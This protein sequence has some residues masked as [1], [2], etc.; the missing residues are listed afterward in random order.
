M[1]TKFRWWIKPPRG[2]GRRRALALAL[3]IATIRRVARTTSLL[4]DSYGRYHRRT[5]VQADVSEDLTR[6]PRQPPR[7][8]GT[9]SAFA[10]AL[11]MHALLA[12]FLFSGMHGPG[13]APAGA[14]PA[15]AGRPAAPRLAA[16][17]PHVPDQPAASF[18]TGQ[19]TRPAAGN[20]Y[21]T[22]A[23]HHKI[24]RPPRARLAPQ[25][26]AHPPPTQRLRTH[27]VE[28]S[29]GEQQANAS[30]AREHETR[31]TALQ[32][33][34]AAPLAD[35]DL[36]ETDRGAAAS[37]GYAGK[38][39]RRV[40]ANVVAPFDIQ[41]NPSAV[42]A[43]TCAPN[44]ALLSATMQRSSGNAQ[45]DSAALS[46]VE[47]SDPMPRDVNGTAPPS[48]LITFQPKG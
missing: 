46:A 37:P 34:A 9:G 32:T 7:E 5:G 13:R 12:A 26:A 20:E 40:R 2:R 25:P 19:A 38:V 14:R 27:V 47:K 10:L 45:W 41:G 23:P 29:K 43:V 1:G 18:V 3:A 21:T 33:M 15:V 11:A 48:F 44:G 24:A 31:L 39:A 6:F 42:I 22:V 4:A 28:V 30:A 8:R 17:T 16:P 36:P 35:N